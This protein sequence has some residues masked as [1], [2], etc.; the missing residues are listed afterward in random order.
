MTKD[1]KYRKVRDLI[2]LACPELM[3]LEFGC[4]VKDKHS[5][6]GKVV[7]ASGR[8]YK[9]KEYIYVTAERHC[10]SFQEAWEEGDFEILG[11]E[12]RL[13]DCLRATNTNHQSSVT[14]DSN[15]FFTAYLV[16][17]IGEEIKSFS[18]KWPLATDRLSDC[19]EATYDFLLAILEK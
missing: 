4:E 13:A 1:Q 8:H 19:D 15:G 9:G 18:G 3:K 7:V 16:G 17:K 5:F 6:I 11:R 12:P 14:I 10:S 2:N